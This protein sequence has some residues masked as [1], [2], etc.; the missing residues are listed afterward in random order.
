MAEIE[1]FRRGGAPPE[2]ASPC[3][4]ACTLDPDSDVCLGC[5]RTLDEITGWSGYS[6]AEKQLVLGKLEGRKREYR[7]AIE[8]RK[9]EL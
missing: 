1:K 2:P 3:V 9:R 8:R 7:S 6:A 4:R 5:Y